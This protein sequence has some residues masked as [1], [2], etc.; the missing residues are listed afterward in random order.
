MVFNIFYI[1]NK[2]F[3][4]TN[5]LIFIKG[6]KFAVANIV[7]HAEKIIFIESL[8]YIILK[9]YLHIFLATFKILFSI[10]L[11]FYFRY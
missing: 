7:V 10:F 1:N 3:F 2:F 6:S 4:T 5:V 8:L 9:K 11:I